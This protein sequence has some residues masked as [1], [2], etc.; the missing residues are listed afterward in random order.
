MKTIKHI[1][2][3][4]NTTEY[5]YLDTKIMIKSK[6]GKGMKAH[7]FWQGKVIFTERYSFV[8][9]D[10]LLNRMKNKVDK[11]KSGEWVPVYFKKSKNVSPPPL[12]SDL[13]YPS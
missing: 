8:R 7:C 2:G 9:P 10:Y 13:G 12:E 1:D 5:E 4:W 6:D 3:I 11:W